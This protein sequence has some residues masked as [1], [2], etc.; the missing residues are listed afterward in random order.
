[1]IFGRFTESRLPLTLNDLGR[2]D[3][4]MAEFQKHADETN[5]KTRTSVLDSYR[6]QKKFKEARHRQDLI[7]G[8]DRCAGEVVVAMI[9]V[10]E[11]NL[12]AI[13]ASTSSI[14]HNSRPERRT[15]RM[16]VS[17]RHMN[18]VLEQF[19]QFSGWFDQ[20]SQ[21]DR[22]HAQVCLDGYIKLIKGPPNCPVRGDTNLK[23]AVIAYLEGKRCNTQERA[24]AGSAP[25]RSST[26]TSVSAAFSNS[27]LSAPFF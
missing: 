23:R 14:R 24:N 27:S 9:A 11:D 13:A 10:I 12:A 25:Q 18:L 6:N 17:E 21:L 2:I 19:P 26:S 8:L 7:D 15:G 20:M 3:H 22:N 16:T 5:T 4:Q 1:M